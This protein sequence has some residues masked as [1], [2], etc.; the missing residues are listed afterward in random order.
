MLIIKREAVL[1]WK[2]ATKKTEHNRLDGSDHTSVNPATDFIQQGIPK[3]SRLH[4]LGEGV[5][6]RICVHACCVRTGFSIPYVCKQTDKNQ[7]TSE[8]GWIVVG[9]FKTMFVK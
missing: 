5:V 3:I 1:E 8:N 7:V 2:S 4:L 9:A 6:N